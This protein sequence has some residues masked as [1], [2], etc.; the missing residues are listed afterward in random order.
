[1]IEA[2]ATTV[3]V[4][5]QPQA[6]K[7]LAQLPRPITEVSAASGVITSTVLFRRTPPGAG[8]P[9]GCDCWLW[10]PDACNELNPSGWGCD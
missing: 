10:T 8:G 1:M 5:P 9:T 4:V 3:A 7:G 2:I 6:E